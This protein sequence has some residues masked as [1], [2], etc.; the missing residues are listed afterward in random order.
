[1]PHSFDLRISPLSDWRGSLTGRLI[2]LRDITER[3]QALDALEQA[4]EEQAAS[5]REN[6]RLY[7]EANSQRQFFE[8]L[9]NACPVAIVSTDIDDKIVACNLAFEQMFGYSQAEIVG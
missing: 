6:A 2:V 9:M 1:M 3:K 8:A 5:A 4:R 7:L